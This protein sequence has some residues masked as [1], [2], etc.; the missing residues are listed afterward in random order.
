MMCTVQMPHEGM[1]KLSISFQS[2]FGQQIRQVFKCTC[3][4]KQFRASYFVFQTIGYSEGSAAATLKPELAFLRFERPR[5]Q[6]EGPPCS[7]FHGRRN[8]DLCIYFA[9]ANTPACNR[10]PRQ[11]INAARKV[12]LVQTADTEP[13][14]PSL[15]F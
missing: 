10:I 2:N 8:G 7:S 15:R 4:A 5:P 13:E 12:V 9:T 6:R 14:A 1:M 11:I 3:T